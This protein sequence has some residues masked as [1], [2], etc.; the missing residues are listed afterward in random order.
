MHYFTYPLK[1]AHHE[2]MKLLRPIAARHD[3]TPA[4]FDLLNTLLVRHHRRGIVPHQVDI[5]KTLHLCRSTICKMVGALEKAGFLTRQVNDI[6]QRYRVLRLTVY[7]RRCLLRVL[8]TLR[9]RE[10]DRALLNAF[11]PMMG[12]SYGRRAAFIH[13]LVNSVRRLDIALNRN[14]ATTFYPVPDPDFHWKFLT[15]PFA[16]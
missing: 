13:R 3:L 2:T 7:G 10:L 11:V 1:R 4:R 15:R 9:R 5:A 8:K 6:D 12:V 14:Y 16:S